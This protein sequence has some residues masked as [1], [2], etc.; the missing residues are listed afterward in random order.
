MKVVGF[1]KDQQLQDRAMGMSTFGCEA[2]ESE[3]KVDKLLGKCGVG[4]LVTPLNLLNP[5]V[6]S[7]HCCNDKSHKGFNSFTQVQSDNAC[8][9]WKSGTSPFLSWGASLTHAV[10]CSGTYLA[11]LHELGLGQ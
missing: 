5:K 1:L 11:L 10:G 3:K 6:Y 9:R 8:L 7:S 4:K 2:E